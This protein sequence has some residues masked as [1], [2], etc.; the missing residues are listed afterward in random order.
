VE[1]KEKN[2]FKRA[3][4]GLLAMAAILCLAAGGLVILVD[5][6]FHNPHDVTAFTGGL[7]TTLENIQSTWPYIR[8][9]VMSP[10][11]AQYMDEDGKLYNGT[12]MDIG[13][14]TLNH[15]LVK[16]VDAAMDCGVSIIDN[17]FGTIN[18]DNYREY[19]TDHMH[20]NEKGREKLADRIADIINNH[21]GT[22]SSSVSQ[23]D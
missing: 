13:N 9:F 1:Q 23:T 12:T 17:Y 19:M 21:L 10:T 11:Y 20:Y 4:A 14:G 2:V 3:T 16:E 7:R 18:E 5:P 22:V 6:F 15:Y 8:I